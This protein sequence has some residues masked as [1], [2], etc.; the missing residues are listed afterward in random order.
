MYRCSRCKRVSAPREPMHKVV[1]ATRPKEYAVRKT[2]EDG[3]SEVVFTHGTE[4][5]KEAKLCG[6]C[7]GSV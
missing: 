3:T 1:T 7:H 2:L 6:G 4:I 5:V